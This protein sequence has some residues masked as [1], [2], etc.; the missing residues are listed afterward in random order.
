VATGN[1]DGFLQLFEIYELPL[2]CE[3]AVLSACS[4]NTGR[5]VAGEGVFAL[6]RGF[7]VAGARRVV[8]SQWA[9]DDDS[10]AELIGGLFKTV[11]ASERAG[12]R[13]DVA[14]ALRD[15]KRKI[16]RTSKWA[17]PFYWAPFILTG[18]D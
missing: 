4:S 14:L 7:L 12:G 9:V 18:V 10:T 3:L 8:A 6:S 16:R 13:P 17:D 2:D 1:D 5:V 15:A 11:A